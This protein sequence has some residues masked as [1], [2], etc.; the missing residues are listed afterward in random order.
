V[1]PGVIRKGKTSPRL[2][3]ALSAAGQTVTGYVAV[4]SDGGTADLQQLRDGTATLTLPAYKKRGD[5]VVTVEYLGS[6]TADPVTRDVT[7][8]VDN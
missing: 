8:H 4:R 7:I 2:D 3:V 5:H 6:D 1:S